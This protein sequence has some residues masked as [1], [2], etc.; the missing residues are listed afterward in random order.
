MALARCLAL[1]VVGLSLVPGSTST[2]EGA[3]RHAP[4]PGV[5]LLRDRA[6][7]GPG[8]PT[9]DAYVHPHARRPRVALLVVHGGSWMS[10]DKR[11]MSSVAR[12]AAARGLAVFNVNYTL[13]LPGRPGFPRQ[14]NQLRAAVGWIRARAAQLN[15]D[16]ER[17][18]VLGTSA[19]G[20]LAALLATTGSG[21][22]A[23][24]E[25]VGVAVTWSA[26]T[27]LGDLG[28]WLGLAVGNLIGCLTEECDGQVMAASPVS[29]VTPDDPPML[30]VH[31]RHEMV[32]VGQARALADRLTEARVRRRLHL[33]PGDRHG[34]R[35]A[36]DVLDASLRFVVRRLTP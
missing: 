33:L 30:I 16:P 4:P 31:S 2:A 3:R 10:G 26:P 32:P 18:G 23:A 28:G 21:S 19:G 22:L 25:R 1:A 24:G 7:A 9:L 20:H 6:Y 35:Y 15:V 11:S 27:H 8:G 14:H 36:A 34:R 12:V 13:A 17:I 5:E 29:H